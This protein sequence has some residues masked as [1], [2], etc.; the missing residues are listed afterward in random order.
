MTSEGALTLNAQNGR[1]DA[2]GATIQSNTSS[3]NAS[4]AKDVDLN[5]ASINSENGKLT[6]TSAETVNLG[7]TDKTK[8]IGAKEIAVTAKNVIL[9][10]RIATS[11]DAITVNATG[12]IAGAASELTSKK[13][14]LD[15]STL[16]MNIERATIKSTETDLT[17]TS[18]SGLIDAKG[19][20]LTSAA[21]TKVSASSG[22][23]LTDATVRSSGD[24]ISVTATNGALDSAGA[25]Y[26][27]GQSFSL[28]AKTNANLKDAT[29]VGT[30]KTLNVTTT[31]G[32]IDLSTSNGG[33]ALTVKTL[34][35]NS[36]SNVNLDSRDV[37]T[38]QALNVAAKG[39]ISA[40]NA[41]LTSPEIFSLVSGD[42]IDVSGST[43]NATSA[44]NNL[45]LK[46]ES[47]SINAKNAMLNSPIAIA[48]TAYDDVSL[49]GTTKVTAPNVALTTR[50]GLVDLSDNVEIT[51]STI[52]LKSEYSDIFLA[53]DVK[54]AATESVS[55]DAGEGILQV[56]KSVIEAP[57]LT[58]VADDSI[59]LQPANGNK[60]PAVILNSAYGSVGFNT[61][62]DITLTVNNNNLIYGDVW[63]EAPGK[64]LTLTNS[65]ASYGQISVRAKSF[66][67]PVLISSDGVYVSTN[68]NN[69]EE[70]TS[71][72]IDGVLSSEIGLMTDKGSI[73]V[74]ILDAIDGSVSVYRT[75]LDTFGTISIGDRSYA[76]SNGFI[77]NGNGNI[78]SG[79]ISDEFVQLM[80]GRTGT[81]T[82]LPNTKGSSSY[83]MHKLSYL[84]SAIN[85]MTLEMADDYKW[86]PMMDWR[87]LGYT[88][89]ARTTDEVWEVYRRE[90][91]HLD[92]PF[93]KKEHIILDNWTK[94]FDSQRIEGV[95]AF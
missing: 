30:D 59:L 65:V 75:S 28:S 58:A 92:E 15:A 86:F 89:I 61:D 63:F 74:G 3:I 33:N 10:N 51:A 16:G 85:E 32:N 12:A 24:S 43:L 79:L 34:T 7:T 6:V 91:K 4:A 73:D 80:I 11:T 1:I 21:D 53:D 46:S 84:S 47:G 23:I 18:A 52:S 56:D 14:A 48:L 90:K 50:K 68:F 17:L 27:S 29:F 45:V 70:G 77:Y 69:D 8:V 66:T 62:V 54:L 36:G 93:A 60:V 76:T 67:A 55:M 95:R 9:N 22:V 26:E 83:V 72:K 5:G 13:V 19:A 38:L 88:Y 20:S 31:T 78:S 41:T 35:L 42:D 87:K 81:V 71:I 37:T 40:R 25:T 82:Q 49:S 39:G 64:K 2:Q 94:T 44:S 57:R